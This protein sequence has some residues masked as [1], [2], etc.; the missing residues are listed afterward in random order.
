MPAFPPFTKPAP[1]ACPDRRRNPTLARMLCDYAHE[2]WAASRPVSPEL[3]RCVGL[4]AAGPMLEDFVRLF[5]RGTG[6]EQQAAALALREATD[7]GAA[8]L[9]ELHANVTRD[10][11][12]S[13]LAWERLAAAGT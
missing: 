2:R 11:R 4:F 12:D 10:G 9:L 6:D 1:C 13:S 7:P 3:W 8:R 5:E